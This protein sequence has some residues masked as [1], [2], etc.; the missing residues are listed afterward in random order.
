MADK[1][2]EP[3]KPDHPVFDFPQGD[4]AEAFVKR[5]GAAGWN[6][7]IGARN[8]RIQLEDEQ[9]YM[10]RVEMPIWH[11][12]D[13]VLGLID[14]K[15]YQSNLK[16]DGSPWELPIPDEWLNCEA[17]RKEFENEPA[18]LLYIS[19]G[20]RSGKTT[21]V[22][23]RAM[24]SLKDNARSRMW[25]FHT[26][27]KM[28]IEYHQV[29]MYYLMPESDRDFKTKV[30]YTSFKEAT[31]FSDAKFI[32]KN[33]SNCEF[34]SYKEDL[35]FAEGGELGA[36]SRKRAVGYVADESCPLF[37]MERLKARI[38]TRNGI[39]LHSYTPVD[40][41]TPI[42]KWFRHGA[43]SVMTMTARHADKVRELP[44]LEVK[45]V[46]VENM[47]PFKAAT[48]FFW[49]EWNPYANFPALRR[50][51]AMDTD[52]Q[53]LIKFY[54]YTKSEKF[55]VFPK[56][57]RNVHSFKLE[58]L[59]KVGTRYMYIDPCGIGRNWVIIWVLVDPSG[60]RWIYREWP[61][62]K[63][64]VDGIG[65]PGP[66]AVDGQ[67]EAHKY[68]GIPG[69]GQKSFGFGIEQYKALIAKL[70]KWNDATSQKT[71]EDWREELGADE[72][73]FMRRIDSRYANNAS[74]KVG[75][76]AL[77]LLEAMR[78][79]H[80]HLEPTS[81]ISIDE[82]VAMINSQLA[83]APAADGKPV[84]MPGLMICEDCENT[85]FCM[86]NWT[87]MGGGKEATKDFVDVVR[88]CAVDD[89]VYID[90]NLKNLGPYGG[91]AG[92]SG[93]SERGNLTM[94]DYFRR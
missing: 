33:G 68:G 67:S 69:D 7:M 12:A 23:D 62:P 41:Y 25:L 28:S 78:D 64:P 66:W 90:P 93:K 57:N 22:L 16:P 42:V 49:S 76:R 31:G 26:T 48:M 17:L 46:H 40:G 21:Y 1:F 27:G 4:D 45:T 43:K 83:Y 6:E 37:L 74:Y 51:H 84:E 32:L 73:V 77:T 60:R 54:G 24:H 29:P 63:I 19:G 56:L 15:Q 30:A 86:Q 11:V 89:A 85:W 65:Y 55:N 5:F 52:E 13:F 82:G 14:W 70:E 38:A 39:G 3:Y 2:L 18:D 79:I 75:G 50:L 36:E 35:L 92:R 34:H 20:N 91:R 53:K 58:D 71:V 80:F 47:P 81:G 9:P 72:V 61:C 59:P 8:K 87:N 44:I 88:Y 94:D 10:F